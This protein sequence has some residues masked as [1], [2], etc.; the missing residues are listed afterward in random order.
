[1]SVVGG[2][3]ASSGRPSRRSADHHAAVATRGV[4]LRHAIQEIVSGEQRFT[5]EVGSGHGHFLTAFATHHPLETCIGIDIAR[6]RVARAQRKRDRAKLQNLHFLRADANEF[7]D[8][9]PV[10]ARLT[11][12]FI[13]FPDP[14]PKR[15]HHKNRLVQSGFLDRIAERVGSDSRLYFRTDYA[16]Y[17]ASVT[18]M[19]AGHT[20]WRVV[21]EP[22]PFELETVFQARAESYQ[23]LVAARRTLS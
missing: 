6:D 20:Q 11:A 23:S 18:K 22:W 1:M 19:I 9:L 17:F 12:I 15:R 16:P 10:S 8:A 3:E 4:A 14:W 5:W 21:E 7:L 13:L 2:A